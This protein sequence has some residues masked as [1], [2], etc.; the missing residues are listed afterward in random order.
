MTV[1]VYTE[2]ILDILDTY[3]VKA[4][5]FVT[6]AQAEEH[7]EW[8][9]EIVERGHTLGMHTY[10]HVYSDIYKSKANFIRDFTK[11]RSYVKETT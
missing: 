9:R 1:P 5:F 3:G 10:S 2:Q 6:G 8:Y 11:L 4:T 7:P